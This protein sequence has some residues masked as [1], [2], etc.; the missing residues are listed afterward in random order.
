MG[1]Q[2]YGREMRKIGRKER[3]MRIETFLITRRGLLLIA[4]TLI[5]AWTS[6]VLAG[7]QFELPQGAF[8]EAEDY[9]G[10]VRDE[11]GFAKVALEVASATARSSSSSPMAVTSLN[12][13]LCGRSAI[14]SCAESQSFAH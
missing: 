13:A 6:P 2:D 3:A 11:A 9:D 1:V 5:L 4:F 10:L 8:F 7:P 14:L 12:S